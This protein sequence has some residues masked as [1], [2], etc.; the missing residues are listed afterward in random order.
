MGTEH[1]QPYQ[2]Y[3]FGS[4]RELSRQQMQA[5]VE[6]FNTPPHAAR[7]R[8]GGRNSVTIAELEGIGSVA[9]K[10]F[11]RG[12]LNRLVVKH[13]Y[14]RWRPRTRCQIE[15][16]MLSQVR[17]LNI[18]APEPV[19]WA[20]RGGLF[21]RGWLVTREIKKH[22]N[23]AELSC[24]APQSTAKIMTNL[25]PQVT[26]LIANGIMHI[27]LHPGNVI[28]DNHDRVF[29][30]DFD[31]ASL[32]TKSPEHLKSRYLRRW[33]RAVQKHGLPQDLWTQFEA[34]L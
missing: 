8:L 15:F 31:K 21:Y 4:R 14:L 9:V 19:A 34:R 13:H 24:Q 20:H 16:D 22:R 33:R 17:R 6:I 30:L 18:M 10:Y 12:G 3:Q 2:S 23:L 25:I 11:T 7:F 32:S 26:T 5:L 27:D 29:L 1:T 28:V